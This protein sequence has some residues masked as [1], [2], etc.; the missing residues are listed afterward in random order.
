MIAVVIT[1][2]NDKA[3]KLLQSLDSVF[4]QTLSAD[5]IIII[6]DG[7]LNPFDGIDR[8]VEHP[9]IRWISNPEN[10]GVSRS[11][12]IAVMS[13]KSDIICFLDT[14][15]CWHQEKLEQQYRLMSI[16]RLDASF[17]GRID[18]FMERYFF[19]NVP[20][21]EKNYVKAFLA[22]N[23][24]FAPSVIMLRKKALIELNG[25]F[26]H[27][28][29]PE[30]RDLGYRLAKNGYKIGFLRE[31]LT[32]LEAGVSSSRSAD[33]E[34]KRKTYVDFIRIHLEDILKENVLSD[35]LSF[36]YKN[37][38]FKY[39]HIND[40]DNSTR[41]IMKAI[42]EK[43]RF[44][45]MI[46]LLI[47]QFFRIFNIKPSLLN[48]IESVVNNYFMRNGVDNEKLNS[49]LNYFYRASL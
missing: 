7:S 34:K 47:F 39:F 17:T 6:D 36:Y 3:E 23:I 40:P 22:R 5:E 24:G 21:E 43:F 20:R 37:I 18:V 12:N 31:P 8:V 33:P 9:N 29:I 27:V 35:S 1:T 28:D 25:F 4:R 42:K 30:D 49:E 13:A 48:V 44:S 32:F 15:D 38:A 45:V 19:I 41:W 46:Y 26:E 11:R 16:R 10:V 14:G 2:F